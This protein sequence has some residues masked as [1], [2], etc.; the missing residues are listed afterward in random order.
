MQNRYVG[1]LGDF[2][3]YGLL[4]SLCLPWRTDAGLPLPSGLTRYPAQRKTTI[5]PTIEGST[6]PLWPPPEEVD[7]GQPLSLGV[8]WYLVPDEDHNDDGKFIQYLD[9]SAI[10]QQRYRHCDPFLYDALRQIVNSGRRNISSIRESQV[11]PY[12]TRFYEAE[13][14][15]DSPSG[16]EP[17]SREDRASHRKTWLLNGLQATYSCDLV[18]V[19]PDNGLE[20]KVSPHEKRGMKYVFFDELVPFL[21]RDQSLVVYHHIGRR[22]SALDQIQERLA[23]IEERLGSSA[24]AFLYHRGSARSF[25]VVPTPRH[26]MNL[27]SGAQRFMLSPWARHFDLVGLSL[28]E[29]TAEQ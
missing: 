28:D 5:E 13:L 21:Q 24:F 20:A 29:F 10:N 19:D 7:I 4:R 8:V 11:L 15:L 6:F 17:M 2:G 14:S 18:F 12:G 9:P 3:K 23:Q 25:F 22:G 27:I 1:D 26:M 16:R